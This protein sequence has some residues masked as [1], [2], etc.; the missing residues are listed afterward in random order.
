MIYVIIIYAATFAYFSTHS[1]DTHYECVQSLE[2]AMD[3]FAEVNPI[4]SFRA[5]CAEMTREE[6]NALLGKEN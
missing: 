5:Q 3:K 2:Q 6:H 1:F 4:L